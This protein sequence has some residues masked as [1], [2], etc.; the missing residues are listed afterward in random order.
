MLSNGTEECRRNSEEKGLCTPQG[1]RDNVLQLK[2]PFLQSYVLCQVHDRSKRK[3]H[4]TFGRFKQ[5]QLKF[6]FTQLVFYFF[7]LYSLQLDASKKNHMFSVLIF[8]KI[9][10]SSRARLKSKETKKSTR[11]VIS[12]VQRVF[13]VSW[14]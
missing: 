9:P 1:K 13:L 2:D 8:L 4:Y 3:L 11:A 12:N 10:L 7:S 5:I 14:S 6:R